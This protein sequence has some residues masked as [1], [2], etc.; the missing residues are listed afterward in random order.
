MYV[1]NHILMKNDLTQLQTEDNVN[2]ALDKIIKGDFLSL[3]VFE[4][5][6]FKG[7]LMKEAIYRSFFEEGHTGQENYLNRVLV[8]DLY[9]EDIKTINENEFIENAA[10]LLNELRTPFLPVLNDEGEFVG[11]L[12][13][14]SIFN[15]FSEVFGLGKGYRIILNVYDRPGQLAKIT[16]IIR[17]AKV[18]I[19]NLAVR[20]AKI[21]NMYKII[22]R[23]KDCNIN[24]LIKKLEDGGFKVSEAIKH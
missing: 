6:K 7:I 16:Q 15:A 11:I 3:P 17:K 12:T 9:K 20:D 21:M 8:K 13:H 1:K 24:E 22:I 19:V 14:S 10:Y 5:E 18:N 4:K 2:T 23:V